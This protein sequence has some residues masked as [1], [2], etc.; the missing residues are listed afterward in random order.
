[1]LKRTSCR[2]NAPI[3]FLLTTEKRWKSRLLHSTSTDIT[4]VGRWGATHYH[5]MKEQVQTS[6]WPHWIAEGGEFRERYLITT[7]WGRNLGPVPGFLEHCLSPESGE[8]LI[9]TSSQVGKSRSSIST[10]QPFQQGKSVKWFLPWYFAEV[11]HLL[12]KFFCLARLYLSRSFGNRE[13]AF[14]GTLFTSTDASVLCG[15]SS[16][17]YDIQEA[18]RKPRELTVTSFLES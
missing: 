9:I 5:Q 8:D 3:L 10:S 11:G 12:S 14:L 18:K 2:K 17:H 15:F 1:M 4:M 13:Q 6:G 7:E 16:N